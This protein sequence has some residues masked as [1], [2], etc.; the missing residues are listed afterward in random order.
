MC[1]NIKNSLSLV[2]E[3]PATLPV[4]L[5]VVLHPLTTIPVERKMNA[6][7]MTYS[8]TRAYIVILISELDFKTVQHVTS[9]SDRK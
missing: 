2:A 8:A 4:V 6:A 3:E 7:V 5:P 1:V 9:A